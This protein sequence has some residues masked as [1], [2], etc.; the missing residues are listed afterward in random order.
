M[1]P[2]DV[3]DEY[4][5]VVSPPIPTMDCLATAT[6]TG[7][8]IDAATMRDI[9]TACPLRMSCDGLA[10]NGSIISATAPDQEE[11]RNGYAGGVAIAAANVTTEAPTDADS[12]LLRA[13]S[14]GA[15]NSPIFR[16]NEKTVRAIARKYGI[17]ISNNKI[18]VK[19]LTQ[20]YG[21]D[22]RYGLTLPNHTIRLYRDAFE[23]EEQLA[24]TLVHEKYHVAQLQAGMPYYMGNYDPTLPHETAAEN[25]AQAWWD[26]LETLDS[27]QYP[28]W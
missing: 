19:P 20:G 14:G 11:H 5:D 12:S 10:D 6:C 27:L 23:S 28:R 7:D 9:L 24:K 25:F 8:G 22:K 26:G 16:A 17:D 13:G 4:P 18:E 15:G 21:G 3:P 2:G 1:T